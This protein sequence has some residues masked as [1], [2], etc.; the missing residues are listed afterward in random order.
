[1]TLAVDNIIDHIIK[2][3][4]GYVNDPSDSGGE[5]NWG[6]TVA[7]ARRCGYTGA[8]KDLPREEAH[9]IYKQEYWLTPKFDEVHKIAPDVAVKLFDIGV[10]MGT[11]RA[12]DF[13]QRVL[14]VF[15]NQQKFYPDLVP[16]KKIGAKTLEA[17]V[18]FKSFRRTEGLRVMLEAITCLQGAFYINLAEQRQK[19]EKFV[20]GWILNRVL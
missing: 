12:I 1:M 16:D 18:A 8:M 5:T 17:L 19:D 7:V 11:G 13:L 14:N 3:E 4:G 6:I 2:V 9:R 10:N 20:Y 15:N